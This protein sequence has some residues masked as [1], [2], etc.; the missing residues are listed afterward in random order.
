MLYNLSIST[1]K[2]TVKQMEN[3]SSSSVKDNIKRRNKIIDLN[4][5]KQKIA[6]FVHENRHHLFN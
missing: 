4:Y 3:E 1:I 5:I 6:D 2:R